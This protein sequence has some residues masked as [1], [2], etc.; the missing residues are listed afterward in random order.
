MILRQIT[1]TIIAL[2][3]GFQAYGQLPLPAIPARLTQPADRADYLAS[4]FY[5]SM[6][7]EN[8]S[9]TAGDNLMQDWANFLSVLP[10]CSATARDSIIT[11]TINAIPGRFVPTYADLADGYLFATD[12][13]LCD[14][15]TYL[16]VLAALSSH[17]SI[18]PAYRS[19]LDSRYKYLSK[20]AP[21]TPATDITVE[22]LDDSDTCPLSDLKDKAPNILIVFYD[23][24]CD[25][26][27]ET[28]ATLSTDPGWTSL[29]Q[30]GK[31]HVVKAMITDELDS[32]YPILNVPSL[33]LLAGSTLTVLSRNTGLD[34]L[35]MLQQ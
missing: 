3:A 18:D 5:D 19:A 21:G 16:K 10:H 7:W 2:L 24:D 25:D 20:C 8:P 15:T 22:T 35:H 33:Y 29:Q 27:H 34:D 31:L 23:P 1:L 6:D 9:M 26:C 11:A 13:E 30:S 32:L 4:H 17:P 28:L 12:S 14:E